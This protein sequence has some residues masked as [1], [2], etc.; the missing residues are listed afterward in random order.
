[1]T[2]DRWLR[3]SPFT[4]SWRHKAM[5]REAGRRVAGGQIVN[6][7]A[8]DVTR[9][10]Y[11][12]EIR[13]EKKLKEGRDETELRRSEGSPVESSDLQL[14]RTNALT[15]AVESRSHPWGSRGRRFKSGRPDKVLVRGHSLIHVF[16]SCLVWDKRRSCSE[17][18]A[19][20]RWERMVGCTG[21]DV[22]G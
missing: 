7:L 15:R 5:A 16:H 9:K 2:A 20:P 17:G 4:F 18:F 8:S 10:D 13:V 1:M 3:I 6:A 11:T 21:I 14:C 19:Q 22:W 12:D